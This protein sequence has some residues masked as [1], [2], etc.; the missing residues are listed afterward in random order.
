MAVYPA[1]FR[2]HALIYFR[3]IF[4]MVGRQSVHLFGIPKFAYNP[5]PVANF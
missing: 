4:F 3:V 1:E 2:V 5:P